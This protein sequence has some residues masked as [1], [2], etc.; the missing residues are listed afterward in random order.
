MLDIDPDEVWLCRGKN[1]GHEHAGDAL[2]YSDQSL[3][4]VRLSI[5]ERLLKI[6]GIC[7]LGSAVRSRDVQVGLLAEGDERCLLVTHD[8]V[9]VTFQQTVCRGGDNQ[10]GFVQGEV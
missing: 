5:L 10:R 2:R 3:V 9:L 1:L 8:G 7:Q 4:S 6:R